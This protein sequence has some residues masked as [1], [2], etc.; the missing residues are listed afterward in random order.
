MEGSVNWRKGNT[1]DYSSSE[2][3]AKPYIE[4]LDSDTD[5]FRKVYKP[6]PP[7]NN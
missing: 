3:I 4:Q 2:S 7:K 6:L 1:R 5:D